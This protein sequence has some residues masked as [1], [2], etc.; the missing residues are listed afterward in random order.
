MKDNYKIGDEVYLECYSSFGA[1]ATGRYPIKGIRTK[2]DPDTG[3]PH[4]EYKVDDNWY[5]STDG[6]AAT[7]PTAYY[8]EDIK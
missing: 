2:Y 1:D 6:S 4:L 7:G 5:N 3:K 8:L